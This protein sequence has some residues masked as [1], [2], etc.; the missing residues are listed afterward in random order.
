MR[1]L[2]KFLS[3]SSSSSSSSPVKC[4]SSARLNGRESGEDSPFYFDKS[5]RARERESLT[6]GFEPL[7]VI[8]R[9]RCRFACSSARAVFFSFSDVCIIWAPR[10]TMC[11]RV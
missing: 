8:Y 7:C 10:A 9:R 11:K 2:R 3:G 1:T 5:S 6:S 4:P